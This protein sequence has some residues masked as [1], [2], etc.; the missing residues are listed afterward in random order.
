[1]KGFKKLLAS[2]LASLLG[3]AGFAGCANN[4]SYE[5]D[6]RDLTP[7]KFTQMSL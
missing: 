7:Q 4:V 2:A 6:M 5:Q 1:M 3:L